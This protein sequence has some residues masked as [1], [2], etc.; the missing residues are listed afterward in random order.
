MMKQLKKEQLEFAVGRLQQLVEF[1]GI[2]QP[3]LEALSGIAQ[4]TISKVLKR[5]R[6]PSP[7]VLKNLYCAIGLKLS[8]VI[9]EIE[10]IGHELIG[11]LAT[12]LTGLTNPEDTELR[13]LVDTI[14]GIVSDTEFDDPHF[15]LYWP[16]DHTHPVKNPDISPNQVY[17]ID[18]SR[19]STYD[20]IV[21]LCVSPSFGV[22]QENEIATQ[23][24]LSAVRLI[25]RGISRMMKGLFRLELRST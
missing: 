25:P 16:G 5:S 9:N 19:A 2:S 6:D 15:E 24:G 21:M 7:E 10:V 17:L 3:Q 23:A 13:I 1:R 14:K 4:S 11:Y 18:R 12:P 22:G 20:F 8:D